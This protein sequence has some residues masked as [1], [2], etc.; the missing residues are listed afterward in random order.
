MLVGTLGLGL[1]WLSHFS[2]MTDQPLTVTYHRYTASWAGAVA[3]GCLLLCILS[4]FGIMVYSG[5]VWMR[6]K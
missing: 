4:V 3:I 2:Q 6:V 1:G 5:Y